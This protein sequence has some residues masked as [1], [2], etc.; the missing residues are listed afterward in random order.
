[1]YLVQWLGFTVPNLIGGA[2]YFPIKSEELLLF[3]SS[4][5]LSWIKCIQGSL[6][7][8]N[9][10]Q[11]GEHGVN[12]RAAVSETWS[13]WVFRS[14]PSQNNQLEQFF[15]ELNELPQNPCN[16]SL[17]SWCEW[18]TNPKF[19]AVPRLTKQRKTCWC[20]TLGSRWNFR[21]R[22][23]AEKSVMWD[24]FPF[25]KWLEDLGGLVIF[26]HLPK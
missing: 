17:N 23:S 4:E 12:K 10:Q 7:H 14:I 18:P 9:L 6:C 21:C 24:W 26:F 2:S 3:L 1:M 13:F 25:Q 15:L 16:S 19:P 11:K 22:S 5:H 8:G 20:R